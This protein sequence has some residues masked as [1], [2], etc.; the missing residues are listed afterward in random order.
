MNKAGVNLRRRSTGQTMLHLACALGLH[1]FVA[2]LLARSVNTD[3]RDN[4]GYT[5]L[6]LAPLNN[7]PEIVRRLICAGADPTI[8]A[9][10]SLTAAEVAERSREVRGRGV[11]AA[12]ALG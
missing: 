6:H 3:V 9:L 12:M 8:R 1:R 7:Q 10:S 4:G 2:G 11:S 5:A